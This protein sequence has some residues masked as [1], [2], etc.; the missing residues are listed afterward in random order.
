MGDTIQ[1]ARTMAD[2]LNSAYVDFVQRRGRLTSAAEFARWLGVSNTSL[3]QW[4]NGNRLPTGDNIHRLA[5]K[6]GPKIYEILELQPLMPDD[7]EFQK[8]AKLWFDASPKAQRA[9]M[10]ILLEDVEDAREKE[11]ATGEL[12]DMQAT[13]PAE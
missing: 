1:E 4:M 12:T 13:N 10:E 9:V 11:K 7:P 5:A 8:Y 6:L 3:S 2:F